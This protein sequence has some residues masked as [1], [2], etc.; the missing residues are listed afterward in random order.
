MWTEEM[1]PMAK[2][3]LTVC[4]FMLLFVLAACQPDQVGG[5]PNPPIVAETAA[6]AEAS[7]SPTIDLS[8]AISEGDWNDLL[9][10]ADLGPR[11]EVEHGGF[12]LDVLEGFYAIYR[13]GMIILR[14]DDGDVALSVGGGLE[15]APVSLETG[16]NNFMRAMLQDITDLTPNEPEVTEV[17]GQ[18]GLAVDFHGVLGDE[19]I[20]GRLLYVINNDLQ[21]LVVLGFSLDDN[22][23]PNGLP[24]YE[25]LLDSIELFPP[26]PMERFCP[27]SADP[28][29]GYTQ[30]NPIR[31]GQGDPIT[32][33]RLERDYLD[34]LRGPNGEQVTYARQGSFATDDTIVD[35]YAVTYGDPE[36]TVLLYLDQYHDGQFRLPQG[37]SC[38]N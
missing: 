1:H 34:L 2:K 11:R 4:L 16:L 36:V 27:V 26:T 17:N 31:V 19:A 33:P 13:P 9:Q 32:G 23:E 35:E 28:N 14:E 24:A 12:S 30:E 38:G 10:V 29:F 6:A 37:F 20:A 18:D 8:T 25:A 22:W 21:F 7:P 15:P 5:G 3:I